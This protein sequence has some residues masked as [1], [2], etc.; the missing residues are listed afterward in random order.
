[1]DRSLKL[2]FS[3]SYS[4]LILKMRL[5]Y[6]AMFCIRTFYSAFYCTVLS[7]YGLISWHTIKSNEKK[8][9][10]ITF[11]TFWLKADNCRCWWRQEKCCMASASISTHLPN[12]TMDP[13]KKS[14][15]CTR[16]MPMKLVFKSNE[17]SCFFASP[18]FLNAALWILS[19]FLRK[20]NRHKIFA[21]NGLVQA[22]HV[23]SAI[24]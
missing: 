11:N 12:L 15:R 9:F 3:R 23:E 21:E 17:I 16:K 19:M 8:M 13:E 10:L 2:S 14:K 1:M 4:C 22:L 24:S 5:V 6:Y 18:S 7:F 20:K